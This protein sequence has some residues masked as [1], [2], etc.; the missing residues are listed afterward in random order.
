MARP[1]EWWTDYEVRTGGDGKV[2]IYLRE[3]NVRLATFNANTRA[4]QTRLKLLFDRAHRHEADRKKPKKRKPKE[5]G[6]AWGPGS[7][8]W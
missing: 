8:H 4:I 5:T 7:G 3:Y 2:G 6:E 1:S